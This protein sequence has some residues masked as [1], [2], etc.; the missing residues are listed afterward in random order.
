MFGRVTPH[1][2]A[3]QQRRLP[4]TPRI[5]SAS[6]L[7]AALLSPSGPP[8]AAQTAPRPAVDILYEP[9][10]DPAHIPLREALQARRVLEKGRDFFL[11][12]KLPKPLTLK[13]ASCDGEPNAWFE[14]ET[15][16]FCYELIDSIFATAQSWRRPDW[17]TENGAIMGPLLEV[18]LHE[19]AHALIHHLNIPVLGREE[20]AADQ[21]A[22]FTILTVFKAEAPALIYGMTYAYLRE[23][24]AH[25]FSRLRRWRIGIVRDQNMA[26]VHSTTLQR[27]Y[28]VLCLA[29]GSDPVLYKD[30]ITKG[31]LPQ[32]RAEGCGDEYRQ[33]AQAF[34]TLLLPHMDHDVLKQLFPQVTLP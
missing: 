18:M 19:G 4:M 29:Y 2:P 20:D 21:I 33:V 34:R 12:F 7:A 1:P 28:A 9:P 6:L 32:E 23:T 27:M 13:I 15:I 26:G 3:R 24:G 10:K 22:A 8:A 5:L 16:T 30:V 17:A 25:N 31:A 11:P 14:E